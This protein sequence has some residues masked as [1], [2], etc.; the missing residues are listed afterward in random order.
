VSRSSRIAGNSSQG[1]GPLWPSPTLLSWFCRQSLH[2]GDVDGAVAKKL[3][4]KKT[5]EAHN[6]GIAPGGHNIMIDV[7]ENEIRGGSLT[8]ASSLIKDE[9]AKLMT[10][11][12]HGDLFRRDA[13]PARGRLF[14]PVRHRSFWEHG[15]NAIARAGDP[16]R[17]LTLPARNRFG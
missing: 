16:S 15:E 1:A 17:R 8:L 5:R 10:A 9:T 7:I 6:F 14:A 11:M 12:A 4:Q 2:D 3:A 13:A